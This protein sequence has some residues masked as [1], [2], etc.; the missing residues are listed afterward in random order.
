MMEYEIEKILSKKVKI[1]LLSKF[2][3]WKF[4]I[5]NLYKR[6]LG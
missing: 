3:L 4:L 6:L 5:K 2:N 1:Y